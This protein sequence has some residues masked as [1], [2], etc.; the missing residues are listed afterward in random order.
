[1][2][3]PGNAQAWNE[4]A[5]LY[6]KL[7]QWAKAAAD[8][9]RVIDLDPKN[10]AALNERAKAQSRL[11]QYDKALADYSKVLE[12][13][14]QNPGVHNNLAWVLATLPDPKLW[15]LGRAVAWAKKAVALAPKEGA[16]WNTLGV[17]H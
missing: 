16:F 9:S 5:A 2:L 12:L 3:D 17:V 11:G 13:N 14:P 4:R 15:D 10:A 6:V 1:E 7:E 8:Y